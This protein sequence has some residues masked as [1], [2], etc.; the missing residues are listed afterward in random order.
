MIVAYSEREPLDL[1]EELRDLG[2]RAGQEERRVGPSTRR[3]P[4]TQGIV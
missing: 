4:G 1:M 2:I 3:T